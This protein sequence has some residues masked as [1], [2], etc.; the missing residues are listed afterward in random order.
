MSAHRLRTRIPFNRPSLAGDELDYVAEAIESGR[1]SGDGPMARRCEELLSAELEGA[2]VLLTPSCTHALEMAA[3]LLDIQP[4]DEVVCPA[5]THPSTVNAFVMRGARPRF[6]D[7]RPDTLNL[8]ESRVEE[9]LGERTA[10]VVCTHYAGVACELD[11]LLA[12]CERQRSRP[13]RGQ[14]PRA[15]RQPSGSSPRNCRPLRR[16]QLPRDE[17]R[18]LRRGR[19]AGRESAGGRARALR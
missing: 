11:P 18:D 15:I 13:G 14:R 17:E 3:L 7:I 5:F 16:A 8:D 2:T 19:G 6:C 10:A 12:T 4:G 9:R 1:L